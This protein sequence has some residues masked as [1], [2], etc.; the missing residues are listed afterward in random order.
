[1]SLANRLTVFRILLA[2]GTFAAL[3]QK[4][5]FWDAAAFIFFV[6]A[7]LTDWFDG[8][9]ARSTNTISSFGKVLDPIADKILVIG[10]LIALIRSGLWIP[11][12]GIFLIIIREL[13]MGG[14]RILAAKGGVVPS[15]E[16]WGKWK[17][18]LQSAS[19]LAMLVFLLIR[20]FF[21]AEVI[22]LLLIP[23][24]LTVVCVISSWSSAYLYFK[25]SRRMLEKTW[26]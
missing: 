18:G 15:A 24:F 21:P 9:I 11:L 12:W 4:N 5:A 10:T 2:L 13:L 22:H 14:L 8:K 3:I 1:M 23:Y 7:L 16:S 26:Q 25:Q 6:I 19:I 17:M 20:D